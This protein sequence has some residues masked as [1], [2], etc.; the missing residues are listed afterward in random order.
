MAADQKL[1][2]LSNCLDYLEG[3]QLMQNGSS[4]ST[5]MHQNV[6]RQFQEGKSM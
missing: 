1:F 4:D 3:L 6:E 5:Q 2:G